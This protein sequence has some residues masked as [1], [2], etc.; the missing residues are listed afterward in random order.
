MDGINVLNKQLLPAKPFRRQ[1]KDKIVQ[2]KFVT[3]DIETV[4]LDGKLIPY[5]ISG[6]NGIDYITSYVDRSPAVMAFDPIVSDTIQQDLFTNFI[7]QLVSPSFIKS[8][9]VYVYAHNLS[10]FDG[11]FLLKHLIP[12][13]KIVPLLFNGQLKSIQ[14]VT[15]SGKT[16]IFKDSYQL[17]PLSLRNL[18]KS[19]GIEM[20][21]GYFPFDLTDVFY[22]G[23]LPNLSY[24]GNIP[25]EEYESLENI[26]HNKMWKFKDEAIKYC[27]LDCK[28]LYELL[29]QFNEL[30]FSEF[31][32]NINNSLTLPALAMKIYK[33]NFMP[34]DSI[35]Q[36][37]GDVEQFI[38]ESYTGGAVDVYIAHNRIT[39]FFRNVTA[40]FKKLYY[41]DVNSL[42][43]FVMAN[44]PMPIG[45]P[46]AF[47]GDIRLVEPNAFGVFYCNITSPGYLKHPIL[48]RK[49]KGHGTVAGLGTWTGWISSMEMDNAVKFGYTFEII[50]GYQFEQG[51]LFSSYVNKLYNLRMEYAKTH[52]MNLIA[53]LLMN[54]LYGKFG[55]KLERTVVN[56]FNLNLTTDKIA[57]KAL[58][59]KVGE[60]IQDHV[61]LGD[62][63]YLFVR[64]TVSNILEEDS[65]HGSDVNI[66]IAS[67]ITA[68]ARVHMSY[69]KNNPLFNLYYSDTDS[70]VVD[71]QINPKM[72]GGALGQVKLEHTIK[73]AVFLAPKVYGLIDVEGNETIKIKGITNEITSTVHINDLEQLLYQDANR[74]FNQHKWYKS[75]VQGNIRITDVLYNLK[76]TSNKRGLVYNDGIFNNTEPLNYEEIDKK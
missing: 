19:F 36:L 3:M 64:S 21:K 18:C 35:Y 68:A 30:I 22:T 75:L 55:M 58:L 41:Y 71:R 54:S 39:S 76:V 15:R 24:W 44:S 17:L 67:T 34:K 45:K 7:E 32:V 33:S 74:V 9:K 29:T 52:P 59:D 72:I 50:K 43:P 60:S 61:D 56:I 66:A 70:A 27:N 11:I 1:A 53:K 73:K 57:L 49:I 8:K 12:F 14:L 28:C 25:M 20:G 31:K 13:G 37:T 23:V 63:K 46:V 5:L 38:R 42:Y 51:D 6:Y 16:I 48:Q 69:F 2:S 10:G 4:N 40:I 65:Y 62:N 47:E 26:F